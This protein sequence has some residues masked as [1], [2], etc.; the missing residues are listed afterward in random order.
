MTFEEANSILSM[1]PLVRRED[2]SEEDYQKENQS[3]CDRLVEAKKAFNRVHATH[4][5][6]ICKRKDVCT[7]WTGIYMLWAVE[8]CNFFE[9]APTIL[10]AST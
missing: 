2:Q 4:I 10:E 6:S 7:Y 9:E 5:C 3:L 8:S 1:G